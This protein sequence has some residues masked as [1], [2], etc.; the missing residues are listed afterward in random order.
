[1]TKRQELRLMH[2][3]RMKV[4]H[5]RPLSRPRF[6]LPLGTRVPICQQIGKSSREK[7]R[8]WTCAVK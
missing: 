7:G 8:V 3:M 2:K 4:R 5:L 6:R 1:M